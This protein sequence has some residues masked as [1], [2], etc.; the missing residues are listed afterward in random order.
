MSKKNNSVASCDSLVVELTDDC[1]TCKTFEEVSSR[2]F[3][4]LWE[5]YH[6]ADG[7]TKERVE[8]VSEDLAE[9]VCLELS[10]R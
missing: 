9:S 2:I 1:K 10:V 4:I 6:G 7:V 5:L 8:T 3:K